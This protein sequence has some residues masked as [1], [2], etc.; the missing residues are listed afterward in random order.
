QAAEA[1]YQRVRV[2]DLETGTP[3]AGEREERVMNRDGLGVALV[4]TGVARIVGVGRR[5][6]RDARAEDVGIEVGWPDP[7]GAQ[8]ERES[9]REEFSPTEEV[10]LGERGLQ[11]RQ[12]ALLE[13]EVGVEPQAPNVARDHQQ[14]DRSR[15]R[16]RWR[17]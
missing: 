8:V 11:Q 5:V 2:H 7:V 6:E 15:L 13:L 16:L 17:N 9:E 10:V 3:L 14:V 12:R 1:A 4:V